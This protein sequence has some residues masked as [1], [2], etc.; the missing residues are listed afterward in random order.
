MKASVL[1][2]LFSASIFAHSSASPAENCLV[3]KCKI[4]DNCRCSSAINPINDAENFAPQLIAITVSESVVQ[5]LYENY[6]KPLF[7]D[8]KN[9]DGGPI[10]LTFYVPHEY[11]DYSLVQDL[12]VRGYE[13]GDHSITKEPNQTY[14]REATS[15][16]LI[17][18]FK[19]QKIIIS[20]FANIP[21][22]DI[23]G[24]RTPQLQLEGDITFSAYEQS[25]LGYD[26]SWPTYAQERILPYTLTYASTQKCTVTIKCPEEQHSGFW[27]APITNIKGVNGTECN[28][29]ATCLV[30]GSADEIADWLFDQVKLYR[31]NNRAPMT[32]R[33]DSY[34][35]LFTENSYEGFTKFLDKIAQ[36]SD[37]FLVS[38]QDILEWIKNPVGYKDYKTP[39]HDDRTADCLSVNCKLKNINNEDR[40]MKSCV[41]CPEVYPWKGNPLGQG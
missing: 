15:D 40:Y 14:W 5:T 41:P 11:T 20:T 13:I 16:D 34:W 38:V 39:V 2:L 9:P 31:D 24:V 30:Q 27:V 18:E 4:E 26:N 6:L 7:F 23:V 19:G 1:V 37:V 25:D 35:F 28:S 3:D 21:Y 8:R 12:Y 36:E 10:G 22:E 33:L 17:D 32:L 29:L